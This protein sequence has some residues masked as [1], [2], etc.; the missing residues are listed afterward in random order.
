L[1]REP[2]DEAMANRVLRGCGCAA[3]NSQ[4]PR[5]PANVVL[6][7]TVLLFCGALAGWLAARGTLTGRALGGGRWDEFEQSKRAARR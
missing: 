7:L 5:P 6:G 4:G 3:P 1:L 2:L